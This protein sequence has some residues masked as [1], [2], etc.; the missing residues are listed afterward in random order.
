MNEQKVVFSLWRYTEWGEV[1]GREEEQEGLYPT[2]FFFGCF[3]LFPLAL[4]HFLCSSHQPY[5]FLPPFHCLS[6]WMALY[7]PS[8]TFP[9]QWKKR[10]GKKCKTNHSDAL[11]NL[12]NEAWENLSHNTCL[13]KIAQG[14]W[15]LPDAAG[16]LWTKRTHTCNPFG[17]GATLS[18]WWVP[19]ERSLGMTDCTLTLQGVEERYSLFMKSK[20]ENPF[21]QADS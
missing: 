10:K 4:Y 21:S 20:M 7:P 3:T 14:D 9:P 1:R 5:V 6:I 16:C 11:H 19:T 8:C 15:L 2:P 12:I 17:F 18:I 13:H